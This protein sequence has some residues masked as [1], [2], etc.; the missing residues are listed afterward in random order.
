MSTTVT[1]GDKEYFPFTGKISYEGPGSKNP[2]AFK[3]YDET[4][5]VAGKTLKDHLRFAVAYWHSFCGTGSD[6]F[7]SG[8]RIFPWDDPADPIRS[9]KAKMDAAFE[10]ITK[11]GAPFYCFHDFD[12]VADADENDIKAGF[13]FGCCARGAAGFD[14]LSR[15]GAPLPPPP[16]SRRL[17]FRR[18]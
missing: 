3:Y 2:M 8:T 13:L 14:L 5:I 16:A 10:F 1:L 6:P 15:R 11:L 17:E 9:G 18:R 7:G 12:L 4:K